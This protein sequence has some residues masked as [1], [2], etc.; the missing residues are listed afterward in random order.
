VLAVAAALL[1]VP[2]A[3]S[4]AQKLAWVPDPRRANAGWVSDPAHHLAPAT[5][6]SLNAVLTQLERETTNEIAVVVIDSLDGLEPADAALLLHRKWGVGKQARD[7]GLLLLWSPA[8]RKI[9][10]SVGQGLEGVIPDARAGRIQDEEM[11]PAFRER[12]F[13]RGILQGVRA[14][15]VAAREETDWRDTRLGY[16][17]GRTGVAP[18]DDGGRRKTGL[19]LTFAAILIAT[20]AGIPLVARWRR[21]RPRQCPNGHGAMR[22]LT[23]AD[24][25]L[26]L[27][28]GERVEESVH[29]VDYDVWV[30]PT[31]EA[32]IK[33]PH[34]SWTSS[35]SPC[36][37]CKR[38]TLQTET[39]TLRSATQFSEGLRRVHR[40]C[41]NCEFDSVT[42]EATP[43]LPPPGSS[44]SSSS[45]GSSGS[46]GSSFGGGSSGGGGAG[47]SY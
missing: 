1:A 46:G 8:L 15:A 7:N 29:S 25:D 43:R 33:V 32:K 4:A 37:E 24:D 38:R 11:L 21:N 36:P 31:C 2:I 5:V 23:E 6:D 14:L 42:E 9:W 20:G 13:D 34:R 26:A 39:T 40:H 28:K 10:V 17:P 41:K 27:E 47:R 44:H 22:R 3:S 45:G 12:A 30:C 16:T 19:F 35:Y 18:A